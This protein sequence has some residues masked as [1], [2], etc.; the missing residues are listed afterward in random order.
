MKQHLK[1]KILRK[2]ELA[3]F[4]ESNPVVQLSQGKFLSYVVITDQDY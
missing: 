4:Y 2:V 3:R 1:K